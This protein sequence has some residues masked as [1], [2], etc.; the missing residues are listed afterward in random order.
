MVTLERT[1]EALIV[2]VAFLVC[3]LVIATAPRRP[4]E[5]QLPEVVP[6]AYCPQAGQRGQHDGMIYTCRTSLR[7]T[8]QR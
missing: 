1:T 8:W 2:F 3:V 4:I 6:G 5:S 7:A